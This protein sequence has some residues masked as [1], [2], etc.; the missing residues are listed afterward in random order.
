MSSPN[1]QPGFGRELRSNVI[2]AALVIG[3]L[4]VTAALWELL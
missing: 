2:A 1:H 4:L 3:G